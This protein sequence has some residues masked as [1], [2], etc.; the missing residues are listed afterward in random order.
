MNQS[1]PPPIYEKYGKNIGVMVGG[2]KILEYEHMV[3]KVGALVY[4]V[5]RNMR[6]V[7]GGGRGVEI[8]IVIKL[9]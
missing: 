3:Q 8:L 7:G 2:L 6:F 1:S 5:G 9:R 4:V